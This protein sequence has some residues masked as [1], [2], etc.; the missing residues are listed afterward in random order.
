MKLVGKPGI[1]CIIIQFSTRDAATLK[2]IIIIIK[3]SSE[4]F[5][6]KALKSVSWNIQA[7]FQ[8]YRWEL[9]GAR[10]AKSDQEEEES[11]H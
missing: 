9:L 6:Q 7:K 4:K 3:L 10:L 1:Y 5:Y 2:I 11:N 8:I